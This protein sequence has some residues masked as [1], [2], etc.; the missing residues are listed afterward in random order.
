MVLLDGVSAVLICKGLAQLIVSGA[1][2]L[3]MQVEQLM[4]KAEQENL[5]QTKR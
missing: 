2:D 1:A 4:A 3:L 5:L